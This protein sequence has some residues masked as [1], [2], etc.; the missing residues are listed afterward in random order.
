MFSGSP[1]AK[2]Y[3]VFD[4][5]FGTS[6][7]S[8]N[9]GTV[10]EALK[11]L[12]ANGVDTR[13]V[14]LAYAYGKNVPERL[15]SN[16]LCTKV[17][18][19][20]DCPIQFSRKVG[21]PAYLTSDLEVVRHDILSHPRDLV[22]CFGMLAAQ[23]LTGCAHS[24]DS[25]HKWRG[26]MLDATGTKRAMVTL[27]PA[28]WLVD[29]SSRF[30]VQHDVRRA[31]SG[32]GEPW[33]RKQYDFSV[34]DPTFES[35][36][37]LLAPAESASVIS[38]DI[39]T[40]NDLITSIAIAWNETD[41]VCIPFVY[42]DD[43]W[44]FS[45][46][47]EAAVVH[48]LSGLL[49]RIP[50][51][52][53]NYNYDRQYFATRWGIA[54]P[55]WHDT[56]GG[57]HVLLNSSIRKDL[58]TLASIHCSDYIFWKDESKS[59]VV[60]AGDDHS[61]WIYNCKDAAYT[62]EIAISQ[63]A[64]LQSAGLYLQ[65]YCW[66]GSFEQAFQTML[67]GT[68][69]DAKKRA[70]LF[71]ESTAL[72]DRYDDLL[73]TIVS[74]ASLNHDGKGKWYNSNKAI[75]QLLYDECGI[76]PIYKRGAGVTT[77]AEALGKIAKKEP[78]LAPLI[79]TILDNRRISKNV[80][81]YLAAKCDGDTR[82]RTMYQAAGTITYRL[83]SQ[84]T[85]FDT[86]MNLQ[87]L[88]K[89]DRHDADPHNPFNLPFDIPS[90]KQLFIPDPDCYI[91]D[92]DLEQADARVVAWDANS[93]Y[94]KGVFN[95]AG[96]DLHTENAKL[97][98]SDNTIDKKHPLRQRAKGGVHAVNYRVAA[99]TLAKTLKVTVDESQHFIDVWLE[100]NPEIVDWHNRLEWEVRSRGYIENVF[101]YRRY[102][103]DRESPQTMSE[104]A[105]WN[106]QSTVAIYINL[107]WQ[108]IVSLAKKEGMRIDVLMQVHDSL[109]IQCPRVII[110]DAL[111]LIKTA[112]DTTI[113]P[114][115]D[116]LIIA[117]GKP[118]ISLSSW[119]AVK[120]VNWDL[121]PLK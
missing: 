32:L 45:S 42:G 61:Q 3:L 10:L 79:Y 95:T 20:A 12:N 93:A 91:I 96:A 107:V 50:N 43:E 57:Q 94:L 72:L 31:I 71:A 120:P 76:A 33:V 8:F 83:A 67:R 52:G 18:E 39:E 36:C 27:S 104:A 68:R 58:A 101:G 48:Y 60:G 1:T 100:K 24:I 46:D 51:I 111:T 28:D 25:Q 74:P 118:E 80:G 73:S 30:L 85:A 53:Q 64:A 56:L 115:P 105:S 66:H 97:I 4:F 65:Y 29:Y 22:L 14:R 49:M 38:V 19:V 103:L 13:S 108:R 26:S 92:V 41:A 77:D 75:Q 121:S 5:P 21:I 106:P 98:F 44:Y 40:A 59:R 87:N 15:M 2:V 90:V 88:T 110:R 6:N 84:K 11:L 35:V 17:K 9:S 78:L 54:P 86:G 70:A 117:C 62:Y 23:T 55:C 69:F 37:D 102:F 81:T 114:Y 7:T 109:V 82:M 116:P 89:G 113:C 99:P 47:E 16:L 63:I 119:D 34:A 112:F